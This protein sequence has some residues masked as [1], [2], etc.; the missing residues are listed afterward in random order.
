MLDAPAK[1]ADA[2]AF[3]QWFT[4][5]DWGSCHV[6]T[7]DF[8]FFAARQCAYSNPL[9]SAVPVTLAAPHLGTV[10]RLAAV[11]TRIE[12]G[13]VYG[14]LDLLGDQVELVSDQPGIVSEQLVGPASLAEFGQPLLR[15]G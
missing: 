4:R 6:R 9:R 7:G 13:A 10:I 12:A 14:V 8:E 2:L 1:L 15:L 3:F 5:S 11:G